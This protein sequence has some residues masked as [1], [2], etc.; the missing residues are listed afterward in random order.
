LFRSRTAWFGCLTFLL[1]AYLGLRFG[2]SV[3]PLAGLLGDKTGYQMQSALL[4]GAFFGLLTWMMPVTM[5]ATGSKEL[6]L[7]Q[8]FRPYAFVYGFLIYY[9]GGLL[10]FIMVFGFLIAKLSLGWLTTSLVLYPVT[11]V[12]APF[13]M[14]F[15]A[16]IWWPLVLH[17]GGLYLGGFV[18]SLLE[19]RAN[20]ALQP[21][22]AALSDS[23][24]V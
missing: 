15:G 11:F 22:A 1:I 24:D 13:Y 7:C 16:G 2:F 5:L 10:G 8:S 23:T 3:L 14:A 19:A 4:V 21:T 12:V 20:N 18:M 9:V 6:V 17:F